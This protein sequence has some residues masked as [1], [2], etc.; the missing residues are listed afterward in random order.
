MNGR[1]DAPAWVRYLFLLT[2]M[3]FV[4][5]LLLLPALN[6]LVQAFAK[7]LGGYVSAATDKDTLHAVFLTTAVALIAI[8]INTVFGVAASWA[9][10]KYEFWGK[11]L[12]VSLI[13]LPFSVSPVVS[14]LIYVLTFGVDTALG[15]WLDTHNIQILY[16]APGIILAT[17]F[18][19]FPFVAREVMPVMEAVGSDQEEAALTLGASGWQTFWQITLPDIKWGVLYGVIL[20]GSRAMGEYGAVSVV[21]GRITG[22][23]DTMSLRVEKLYQEYQTQAAFTVASLLLFLAFVTLAVKAAVEWRLRRALAEAARRPEAR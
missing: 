11:T 2:A 21:S 15:S 6:V 23:T 16:A 14:G 17:T 19:T 4:V 10:T 13:D 18:V 1:D 3:A 8:A 20:C 9:I 12:L 7:G 5:V 22:K